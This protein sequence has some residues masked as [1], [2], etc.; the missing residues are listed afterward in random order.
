MS[1]PDNNNI[2]TSGGKTIDNP[3]LVYNM[4]TADEMPD[5]KNLRCDK[6][7]SMIGGENSDDVNIN[8]YDE[9]NNTGMAGKKETDSYDAEI[10]LDPLSK[11]GL[12]SDYDAQWPKTPSVPSSSKMS[13]TDDNTNLDKHHFAKDDVKDYNMED[14]GKYANEVD[15]E[16]DAD[17]NVEEDE[18]EDVDVDVDVDVDEDED[19]DQDDSNDALYEEESYDISSELDESMENEEEAEDADDHVA[20]AVPKK[21]GRNYKKLSAS[22]PNFADRV[23]LLLTYDMDFGSPSPVHIYI[24]P[25]NVR[26]G[27]WLHEKCKKYKDGRLYESR[28][29]T[30]N[31]LGVQFEKQ[32]NVVGK[33]Y[34]VVS[35]I[36]A[37]HKY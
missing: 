35:N 9:N 11:A 13:T 28:V 30:L 20:K 10:T 24:T 32:R 3:K 29:K 6:V 19:V 27:D 36:S 14:V 5:D 8:D 22:D 37:I 21:G 18:D 33:R 2:N 17:D 25:D 1:S 7:D 23:A 34:T 12:L 26:L 4:T 15:D 31:G 16:D